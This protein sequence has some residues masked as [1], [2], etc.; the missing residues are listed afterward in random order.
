MSS[1]YSWFTVQRP[2]SE[3][4]LPLIY[5]LEVGKVGNC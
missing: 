3:M 4:L 2:F 5:Y 1:I